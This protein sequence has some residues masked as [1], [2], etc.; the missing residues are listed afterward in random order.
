VVDSFP[1]VYY[2][3]AIMRKMLKLFTIVSCVLILSC[4]KEVVKPPEEE[5]QPEEPL[6]INI[7]IPKEKKVREAL[8]EKAKEVVEKLSLDTK[9]GQMIISYPPSNEFVKQQKIGGVILN[10]NFIRSKEKTKKLIEEYNKQTLIPLFFAIDQ[11]GGKVNRL[12]HIE[13]YHKT[14]SAMELGDS[15]SEEELVAYAYST[16]LTMRSMGLNVNLAPS[17]DLT[18]SEKSL[19]SKQERSL[20]GDPFVVKRKSESLID[21]YRAGGVLTFAKHYPGYSDVEINSDVSVAYFDNTPLKMVRN[22]TLFSSLASKIDGVMMSS[23]IYSEFDTFPALYSKPLIELVRISNPDILVM[24]DDL[25]APALRILDHEDLSLITKRAFSAGNDILLIL[26]DIKVLILKEA[27]L[28]ILAQDPES[29]KQIDAS[30]IR[31][32]LAKEK[33]YPGLIE[34][35]H[36]KFFPPEPSEE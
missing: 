15:Y 29:E 14:P 32:L 27:I 35:L 6:I 1:Y 28:E 3:D 31:I 7:V 24:T 19:M 16:A 21:G 10:Q 23:V 11:E 5:I 18:E 25:Y 13:G 26:W 2:D 4:T 12:K 30:V 8:R 9:I 20:G 34:K 33:I 36:K 22:Y 17:L